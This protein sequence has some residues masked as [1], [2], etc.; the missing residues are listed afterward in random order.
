MAGRNQGRRT[1]RAWQGGAET[2]CEVWCN[3]EVFL[4]GL[5]ESAIDRH[6]VHSIDSLI[7]H[8]KG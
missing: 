7:L 6:T 5:P 3:L 8:E 1:T 4:K 2:Y